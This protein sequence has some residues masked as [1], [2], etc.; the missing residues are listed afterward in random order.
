MTAATSE[1]KALQTTPCA[2]VRPTR[3]VQLTGLLHCDDVSIV[4]DTPMDGHGLVMLRHFQTAWTAYWVDMRP[5]ELPIDRFI[6][7][8]AADLVQSFFYGTPTIATRDRNK[9]Y[10][11]LMHLIGQIKP[12]L[13]QSRKEIVGYA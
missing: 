11:N 10:A 2:V 7:T 6:S 13:I 3:L 12:L 8:S 4:F 1:T 5:F 9:E